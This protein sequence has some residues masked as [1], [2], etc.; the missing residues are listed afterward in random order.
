MPQHEVRFSLHVDAPPEKVFAFCA[1]HARFASLFGGK[2]VRIKEG[3]SEPNGVGSVRR[4]GSGLLAFEETIVRYEPRRQIDYTIT[5]G[6]PL[7]NHLGQIRFRTSRGGT[8]ID[9]VI[10]YDARIPFTGGL[11]GAL[12]RLGWNAQAPKQ[13][14]RLE[15]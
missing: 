13:L 2:A 7:K 9:Y 6:S 4:I 5:R 10:R 1:D 11:I 12:L 15:S 14:G 8:E 3:D